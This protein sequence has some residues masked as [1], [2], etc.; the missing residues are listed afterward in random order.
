MSNLS[1]AL[2]LAQ[3]ENLN[4]FLKYKRK[5]YKKYNKAFKFFKK[6]RI[7]KEPKNSKSN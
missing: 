6:A 3:L 7:F 5:L 1:A 4:R 2:G